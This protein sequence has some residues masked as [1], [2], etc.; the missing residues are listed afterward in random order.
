ME[1]RRL[2]PVVGMGTYNT[3]RGDVR[4]AGEVAGT[5]LAARTTLFDSSPMYG[6]AEASLGTALRD[7]RDGVTVATLAR[8]A[9]TELDLAAAAYARIESSA[10]ALE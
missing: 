10:A 3:F 4:L 6:A 7:R 1:T 8:G 2:G 5:A 9:F